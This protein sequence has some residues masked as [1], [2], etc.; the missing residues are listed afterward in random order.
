MMKPWMSLRAVAGATSEGVGAHF[1][2]GKT[3]VS[4]LDIA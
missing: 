2:S 1:P 4:Y 3:Q